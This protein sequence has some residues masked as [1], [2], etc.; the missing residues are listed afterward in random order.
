MSDGTA[1]APVVTL[2]TDFG[3][4]SPYVAAMKAVLLAG[5]PGV[6]LVDVSHEVPPFDVLPG[7][8]L[9]WAGTRHF[10]PGA[11]H[12][13]VVDPGVGSQRRPIALL[14]GGSW[15]VGPD[16]GLF[17]LV[18]ERQ[19]KEVEAVE[20]ERRP[21]ISLTFEGRDVFAPAAAALAAGRPYSE[22]GRPTTEPP[23]RLPVHGPVVLWVDNFGNL[24]TNLEG[25]VAGLGIN[26]RELRATALTYAEAPP[27]EP[28]IY[29]GSM[30]LVEVGIAGHRADVALGARPG[31]PVEVLS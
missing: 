10:L 24:V 25:P 16:N 2:T 22:L 31:L 18:L 26:G 13:A 29:V 27:G 12:L 11:V 21:G 30:G 1:R 6:T 8:F 20:L 14:V 3:P 17:G 9:L 23:Q 28:F 15:Y 19:G 4:S 7:A 5:C